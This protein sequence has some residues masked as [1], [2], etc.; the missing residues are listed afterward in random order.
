M[1]CIARV[2]SVCAKTH[3]KCVLSQVTPLLSRIG[4]RYIEP[5]AHS[6]FRC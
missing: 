6:S 1:S 3:R 5:R 2:L 4:D